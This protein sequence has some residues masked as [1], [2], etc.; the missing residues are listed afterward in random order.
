MGVRG[1]LPPPLLLCHGVA[2]VR[3]YPPTSLANYTRQ[4]GENYIRDT[5]RTEL[6]LLLIECHDPENGSRF[7]LGQNCRTGPAGFSACEPDPRV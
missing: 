3:K 2:R 4:A 5:I 6:V 7:S 1:Y